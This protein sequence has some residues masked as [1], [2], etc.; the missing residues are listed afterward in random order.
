MKRI[1]FFH[2]FFLKHLR[3]T[4]IFINYLIPVSWDGEEK[5][6]IKTVILVIVSKGCVSIPT[7]PFMQ[8]GS[9]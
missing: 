6:E 3:D 5:K 2:V 8:Q 7:V 1:S 9:K 4:F